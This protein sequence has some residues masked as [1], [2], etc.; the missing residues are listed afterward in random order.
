M[1]KTSQSKPASP[2][3]SSLY[4]RIS[5]RVGL[6]FYRRNQAKKIRARVRSEF[7]ELVASDPDNLLLPFE[8]EIGD[9]AIKMSKQGHSGFSAPFAIYAI[10]NG[11]EKILAHE[12]ILG[13]RGNHDEFE[14]VAEPF[15]HV[16]YQNK[17]LSSVFKKGPHDKP[18]F[19]DAF[20]FYP[21]GKRSNTFTSNSIYCKVDGEWKKLNSAATIKKFPF[22]KKTFYV[23]VLEQEFKKDGDIYTPQDGGGW[24]VSVLKNFNDI[25][26]AKDY[27][28]PILNP[29]S[30]E[31]EAMT[32]ICESMLTQGIRNNKRRR[33]QVKKIKN[34]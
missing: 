20:V 34:T 15:G 1:E 8:K 28:D 11:V 19:I 26:V 21:K 33:K 29:L 24:W 30:K 7:D 5:D 6:Y 10:K 32:Y 13:I 3:K 17:K 14:C 23:E 9:I 25:N 4:R 22:H 12:P 16:Y 31:D 2:I 27:F 18:Y